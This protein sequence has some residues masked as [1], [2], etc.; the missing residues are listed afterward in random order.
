M[1]NFPILRTNSTDRL[2]E[3]W[4]RGGDGVQNSENLSC[5]LYSLPQINSI[6][7]P[8]N[9]YLERVDLVRFWRVRSGAGGDVDEH[10][11]EGD[12]DRHPPGHDRGWDQETDLGGI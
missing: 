1:E 3:M 2:R 7:E 10:E 9:E 4:M 8:N 11:E 12:Q 6:L 5:S